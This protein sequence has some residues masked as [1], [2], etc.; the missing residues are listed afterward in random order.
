MRLTEQIYSGKTVR[1]GGLD[2]EM[3]CVDVPRA[4]TYT[5]DPC[6]GVKNRS[7]DAIVKLPVLDRAL[8]C[9]LPPLPVLHTLFVAD[10]KTIAQEMCPRLQ[11]WRKV[12][13]HAPRGTTA[14]TRATRLRR[15]SFALLD[16]TARADPPPRPRAVLVFTAQS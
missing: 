4:S 11:A 1:L 9:Y 5:L 14:Q 13:S 2:L 6:G 8:P 12:V 7:S 10:S 16:T 3:A 15:G